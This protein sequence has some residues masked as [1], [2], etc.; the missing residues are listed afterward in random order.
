MSNLRRCLV[1]DLEDIVSKEK[2]SSH[3][4]HV[5]SN[6]RCLQAATRIKLVT[7]KRNAKVKHKNGPKFKIKAALPRKI[8][9]RINCN[10]V[11]LKT[12]RKIY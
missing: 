4:I 12:N 7:N 1:E 3:S 6:K 2:S 11:S 10:S 5:S 8:S 9:N